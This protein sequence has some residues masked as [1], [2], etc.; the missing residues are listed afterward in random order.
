MVESKG[1]N[2]GFLLAPPR[3]GSTMLG[4]ILNAHS[5][6]HCPPEPWFQLLLSSFKR[7]KGFSSAV[8]NHELAVDALKE[9]VPRKTT[10]QAEQVYSKL[11][12]NSILKSVDKVFFID[13][14]PRYYH[15]AEDLIKTWTQAKFI[16]LKRN[17]FDTIASC[18]ISWGIS[19]KEQLG[20]PIS[21]HSYD[22]TVSHTNHL[23]V[24]STASKRKFILKYEDLV[25]DPTNEIKKLCRFLQLDFENNIIDYG[26]SKDFRISY[27]KAAFGDRNVANSTS[28]NTN[29]VGKWKS[30]LDREEVEYII[31]SLGS[32]LFQRLGYQEEL[33][34]AASFCSRSASSIP[35]TGDWNKRVFSLGHHKTLDEELRFG[36]ARTQI[37]Y[38]EK[39]FEERGDAIELL[40]EELETL[41]NRCALLEAINTE[42]ERQ[43]L[44][45]E[46]DRVARGEVIEAQ[47]GKNIHLESEL[48]RWIKE[49]G[50]LGEKLE[51]SH[52]AQVLLE[53]EK[54]EVERQF[55]EVEKD[56]IARGKVIEE[57][58]ADN[59][60]LQSE[61]DRWLK[62]ASTL[63][64]RLE[65]CMNAQALLELEKSEIERQFS[66]VEKDRVERG[67]VIEEQ[68]VESARLHSEVDRWLNEAIKLGD[69]L[70]KCRNANQLLK[71]QD[72]E[73]TRQF[74]E[75][76]NDRILRGEV[77]KKQG[78]ESAQLNAK[79]DSWLK[80]AREFS[81]SLSLEIERLNGELSDA[82]SKIS[83]RESSIS[84]LREALEDAILRKDSYSQKL[85]E[86]RSSFG[87]LE[88][89]V[90]NLKEKWWYRLAQFL[91]L[92]GTK[93]I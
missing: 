15:I 73:L 9:L 70:E 14:T 20:D 33:D 55:S 86:I 53:L 26:S 61:L 19:V 7:S 92:P 21:S 28:P 66:E 34:E 80:E 32:A 40:G 57:I 72:A 5:Q 82:L 30:R 46:N 25:S 6:L 12:Y 75:V 31:D 83:K 1:K 24:F 62:E 56:R 90:H 38:L 71:I 4:A 76:E 51:K 18:K 48:D 22:S 8:F 27:S 13:K 42:R 60:Q 89:R 63:G 29:S 2:L 91:K 81:D 36:K 67:K 37:E 45:V 50:D 3:S 11:I 79:V 77:I 49:A 85:C 68:G 39:V 87:D 17:P 84:T 58:G 41:K 52:N 43:F 16:W 10:H 74:K 35:E 93:D 59:S 64:K 23:K 69:N 88:Q 47:G 65:T 54:K 44:K 78:A